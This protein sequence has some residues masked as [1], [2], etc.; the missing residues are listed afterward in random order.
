MV[1]LVSWESGEPVVWVAPKA[2]FPVW[3]GSYD[4]QS[5]CKAAAQW[6]TDKGQADADLVFSVL[7]LP[8][9]CIDSLHLQSGSLWLPVD[10][11]MEDVVDRQL[12]EAL[13]TGVR[14][15][16]SFQTPTSIVQSQWLAW[17]V[18]G[19]VAS[20]QVAPDASVDEEAVW[21]ASVLEDRRAEEAVQMKLRSMKVDSALYT[22]WADSMS[23]VDPAATP[24]ALRRKFCFCE[25]PVD[26]FGQDLKHSDPHEQLQSGHRCHQ[27]RVACLERHQKGGCLGCGLLAG[28]TRDLVSS[29]MRDLTVWM[30]GLFVT[31]PNMVVI[32]ES[33]FMPWTFEA[34]YEFH[35]R[36][37]WA[38]PVRVHE[39]LPNNLNLDF[40]ELFLRDYPDQEL[41]SFM[42]LGV[43]YKA[44]LA[45]QVVLL[46]HLQSFLPM[47]EKY[48]KQA[49]QRM[50][51]GWTVTY[52]AVVSI[53]WRTVMNGAIARRLGPE[54]SRITNN[55]S[56]P[57]NSPVDL[58]GEKVVPL[59]RAIRGDLLETKVTPTASM[60]ITSI[61]ILLSV[62]ALLSLRLFLFCDDFASFCNQMRLALSEV[63]RTGGILPPRKLTL[64]L[65]QP[66]RFAGDTVLGFGITMA[67][68]IC[69]RSASWMMNVFC[70]I[71]D[72]ELEQLVAKYRR[73]FRTRRNAKSWLPLQT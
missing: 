66:A 41:A 28:V 14:L 63:Y 13:L 23:F 67:S 4:Q 8:V 18:L 39:P 34:L 33:W 20:E 9:E 49:D 51:L 19:K 37:G 2:S 62:A 32:P 58:D 43:R 12:L 64:G 71:L 17:R 57:H 55:A 61:A 56:A 60:I 27:S 59:N 65:P 30:Q 48:L 38:V 52:D 1:Q 68:N 21:L 11:L 22:E 15:L 31:C 46:P 24:A 10:R 53:P 6:T 44:D 36:P 50:E 25:A 3:R 47:Q 70:T 73:Q 35:S 7:E 42:M 54:K 69:Q 26:D 40:M 5:V 45:H 72:T 29:F 16:E